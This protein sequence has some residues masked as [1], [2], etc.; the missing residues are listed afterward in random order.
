MRREEGE[1]P[2]KTAWLCVERRRTVIPSRGQPL[3]RA[4]SATVIE[5]HYP[6]AIRK[7]A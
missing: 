1:R 4:Y 7:K 2:G 6:G 3:G 5:M